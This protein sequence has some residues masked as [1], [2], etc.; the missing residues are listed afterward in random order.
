MTK[1]IVIVGAGGF[2]REALDIIEAV[3]AI[4]LTWDFLG[5]LDDGNPDNAL[6]ARRGAQHLGPSDA[7]GD[8][9]AEY[10]IGI[11]SGEVRARIDE[12]AT[13]VGRR[14]ITLMH[15]SATVGSDVELGEGTIICS[16]VSITT[17]VTLCLLYTSRCV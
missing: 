11:G 1:P 12:L 15:P 7:L 3:N 8:I 6:L 16:Q 17:H 10:V 5:F 4:E 9:D 13:S 14:S 2:G